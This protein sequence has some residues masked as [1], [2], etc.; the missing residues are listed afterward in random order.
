MLARCCALNPD[1]LFSQRS[2]TKFLHLTLTR[3][4]NLQHVY[5]NTNGV[6]KRF[7]HSSIYFL[8]MSSNPEIKHFNPWIS[9]YCIDWPYSD[10]KNLFCFDTLYLLFSG[11][12]EMRRIR[13][14]N[15]DLSWLY[16]Y[17]VKLNIFF[18][19][20]GLIALLIQIWYYNFR[21]SRHAHPCS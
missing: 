16:F 7:D 18:S 4:H 12:S 11:L 9:T 2:L 17:L 19:W 6:S 21:P 8:S 10:I 15:W 14:G 5:A 3:N 13:H 1:S 20:W